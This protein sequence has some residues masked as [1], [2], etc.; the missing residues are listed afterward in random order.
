MRLVNTFI[1]QSRVKSA[2]STLGYDR[3]RNRIVEY[4][5]ETAHGYGDVYEIE[6]D[7]H[8]SL[9]MDRFNLTKEQLIEFIGNAY[10]T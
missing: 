7:D 1:C 8:I 5:H 6:V 9:I 2:F 3:V 4:F 10:Q